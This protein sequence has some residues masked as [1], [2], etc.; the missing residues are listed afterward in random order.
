MGDSRTRGSPG[1]TEPVQRWECRCR[2]PAVLLGTFDRHG[3]INIKVR[4]RYWHVEGIVRTTCPRCGVEHVLDLR[5]DRH[6]TPV[7]V[8]A[9]GSA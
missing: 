6:R 1:N 7:T 8:A 4:D 2:E 5:P 9:V 3:R